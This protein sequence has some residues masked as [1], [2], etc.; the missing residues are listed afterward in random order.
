MLL[1]CRPSSPRSTIEVCDHYNSY[2]CLLPV[3]PHRTCFRFSMVLCAGIPMTVHHYT[4]CIDAANRM[5]GTGMGWELWR[6][7][8]V[9]GVEP[10]NY[11]YSAI[12]TTAAIDRDVRTALRLL[13]E[14][15]T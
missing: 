14:M 12:I 8:G 11:A 3:S 2:P 4:T 7:M 9:K 15:K 5:E 1:Q 10:N 6:Q 13:E